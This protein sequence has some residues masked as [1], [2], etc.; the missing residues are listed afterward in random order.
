MKRTARGI[1]LFLCL[2]LGMSLIG[3][4][5][6]AEPMPIDQAEIEQW[7]VVTPSKI[8]DLLKRDFEIFYLGSWNEWHLFRYCGYTDATAI[9]PMWKGVFKCAT[10]RLDLDQQA[11]LDLTFEKKVVPLS[12]RRVLRLDPEGTKLTLGPTV[13]DQAL[14]ELVREGMLPPAESAPSST[15]NLIDQPTT[16]T[17]P[18]KH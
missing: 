18:A 2:A 8:A 13:I 9:H 17:P 5:G 6:L 11:K 3:G 7:E 4:G 12:Q 14:K 10:E 16:N 1:L 15:T